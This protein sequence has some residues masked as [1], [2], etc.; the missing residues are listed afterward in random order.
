MY[1]WGALTRVGGNCELGRN[2]IS[3]WTPGLPTTAN[4]EERGWQRCLP[5]PKA[6]PLF[7][8]FPCLHLD[9]HAARPGAGA[10]M[11]RA[12]ATVNLPLGVEPALVWP[13]GL[14]PQVAGGAPWGHRPSMRN[15]SQ[16]PSQ[17]SEHMVG[18]SG[19]AQGPKLTG[20]WVL[21]LPGVLEHP[22]VRS[23]SRW[24]SHS[25]RQNPR[26]GL[27]DSQAH[28]TWDGHCLPTLPNTAVV[29][30]PKVSAVGIRV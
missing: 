22:T 9:S 19:L 5:A 13:C 23:I 6:P 4:V 21:D 11:P 26:T 25:A 29:T 28:V 10:G 30:R 20:K 16:G 24:P 15:V 14:V 8:D 18:L 27:M 1:K 2:Q 17:W 3:P 7:V 12:L